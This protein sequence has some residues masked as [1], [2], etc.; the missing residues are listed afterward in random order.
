M[1]DLEDMIGEW[2][3]SLPAG[4]RKDTI[5]EIEDHLRQKFKDLRSAH[6]DAQTAFATALREIGSPA[7]IAAE[8]A[9]VETKLWWPV[10]LGIAVLCVVAVL[11]VGFLIGRLRDRPLGLLLGVHVFTVTVGYLTVFTIGIFGSCFVLQRCL[12]EFPSA[13]ANE[14]TRIAAKFAAIALPFIAIAIVLGAVWAN[15]TWGRAWSNDPKEL[16]ALCILGWTI[17]FI[18]AERS[19]AV[20]ARAIMM[21]A[22]FGN[23]VVSCGWLG[24]NFLMTHSEFAKAQFLALV[25]AHAFLFAIG[26]LPAGWLRLTKESI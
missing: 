17:G 12:G 26:F 25:C 11:T 14:I 13:K 20:S 2:R 4:M 21:L 7:Q 6:P 5:D 22:I 3:R 23:I 1:R 24:A 19:G 16:G 15:L 8:F 18:A 10:K 9:K